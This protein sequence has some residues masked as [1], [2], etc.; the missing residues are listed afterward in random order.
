M[1]FVPATWP[2]DVRFVIEMPRATHTGRPPCVA[3]MPK[4][5]DTL[6]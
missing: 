5:N 3:I 6:M 2:A 1:R 4:A